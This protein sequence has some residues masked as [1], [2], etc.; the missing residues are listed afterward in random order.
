LSV[1]VPSSA[2]TI[3]C[4][5]A[6][7]NYNQLH[8]YGIGLNCQITVVSLLLADNYSSLVLSPLYRVN[9][10]VISPQIRLPEPREARVSGL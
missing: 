5:N 2:D 4:Q 6:L 3:A 10:P 9:Q 7:C 1:H 8:F